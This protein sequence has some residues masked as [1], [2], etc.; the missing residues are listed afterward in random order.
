MMGERKEILQEHGRRHLLI[1]RISCHSYC[2]T[3]KTSSRPFPDHCS[4]KT[5]LKKRQGNP[6]LGQL[7]KIPVHMFW[8]FSQAPS[9][10]NRKIFYPTKP[11]ERCRNTKRLQKNKVRNNKTLHYMLKHVSE[12]VTS[13][14]PIKTTQSRQC[15]KMKKT[16]NGISACRNFIQHKKFK[17]KKPN[18]LHQLEK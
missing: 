12:L 9:P 1:P 6:G 16:K 13:H 17:T 18:E 5:H 11:D 15:W 8:F 7:L 4:C 10:R 2:T 3:D 14:H